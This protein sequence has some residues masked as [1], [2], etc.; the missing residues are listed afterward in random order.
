MDSKFLVVPCKS[1]YKC[2]LNR[3]FVL[4]LDVL[5]SP[6]HL[7]FKFHNI[8]VKS[9]TINSKLEGAKKIYQALQQA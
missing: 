8:H 2:I 3:P 9:I 5:G 1:I 7:K 6:I 4:A